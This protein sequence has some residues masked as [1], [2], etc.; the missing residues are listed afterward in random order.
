MNNE[1]TSDAR[2][3]V[4]G[5]SSSPL[6]EVIQIDQNLIKDHLDKGQA[7]GVVSDRRTTS[8]SAIDR[9]HF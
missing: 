3:G 9:H 5:R 8:W 1:T 7:D 6:G 2:P 4:A